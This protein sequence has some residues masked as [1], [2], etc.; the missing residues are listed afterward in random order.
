MRDVLYRLS[1]ISVDNTF[2]NFDMFLFKKV[3]TF[4]NEKTH[5]IMKYLLVSWNR[6]ETEVRDPAISQIEFLVTMVHGFQPVT[7]DTKSPI[8]EQN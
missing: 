5:Y 8:L 2:S 3:H 1:K 4:Y 7:N 6:L